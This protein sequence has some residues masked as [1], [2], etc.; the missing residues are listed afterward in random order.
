MSVDELLGRWL[1]NS[2]S[3]AV[4][5]VALILGGAG[6]DLELDAL[7]LQDI[8]ELTLLSVGGRHCDGLMLLFAQE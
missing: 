6:L 3:R 2:L 5:E 1:Q 7:V 4:Q 8:L